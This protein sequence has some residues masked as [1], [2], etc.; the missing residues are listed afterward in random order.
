VCWRARHVTRAKETTPLN[1][2]GCH[3]TSVQSS[4]GGQSSPHLPYHAWRVGVRLSVTPTGTCHLKRN[5]AC[6]TE[7]TA[8]PEIAVS[9]VC[10]TV[11][12]TRCFFTVSKDKMGVCFWEGDRR[13][14]CPVSHDT[15]HCSVWPHGIRRMA[16]VVVKSHSDTRCAYIASPRRRMG[17]AAVF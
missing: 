3:C 8:L 16:F 4:R 13:R 5:L 10:L 11:C 1:R 17:C 6:V 12:V 14:N 7:D 2:L 9:P 15:S